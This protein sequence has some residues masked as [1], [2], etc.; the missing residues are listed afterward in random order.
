[1][2]LLLFRRGPGHD[3]DVTVGQGGVEKTTKI[4]D[5]IILPEDLGKRLD[6]LAKSIRGARKLR[7][8]LRHLLL[9]GPPGTGKTMVARRLSQ[10][11]GLDWAIMSGGDVGPLGAAGFDRDPRHPELGATKPERVT[12]LRGRGRGGFMRS[13][14]A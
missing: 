11:S 2:T 12:A 1:M 3:G 13:R 6:Q 7:A 4:T 5:G 14:A 10:I 8:P 9:F